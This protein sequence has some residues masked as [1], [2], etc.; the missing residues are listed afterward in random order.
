[1]SSG[2]SAST[3]AR[4]SRAS[5][6]SGAPLPFGASTWDPSLRHLLADG[7]SGTELMK[8]GLRQGECPDA[9]S[10]DRPRDV[11]DLAAA[12]Y[13]A[14]SDIVLTNSFG[15]SRILLERHGLS[16]RTREINLAA[17]RIAASARDQA[18]AA[19]SGPAA[20]SGSVAAKARPLA[21]AGDIG[22]CGK[23]FVMGEVEED[24][25]YD[26]FAEQAQALAE[27]GADWFVVE[28]MMDMGEMEIAVRAAAAT[29]KPV[30]ASMTYQPTPMGFRTLMGNSPEDC[31][32]AAT[33]A[34]AALI[35]ANCGSGVDAYV[36]LARTLRGLTALP[37]WIK[38][39]AGLPE[40]V[41]GKTVH[42]MG[43]ETYAAFIPALLEAGADV[44]G[45]CCG[46][47]PDYIRMIRPLVR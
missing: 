15:A 14:G 4:P 18:M 33:A 36:E 19:A 27:G 1:M 38:A 26:A 12:Y 7:A 39:N 37:L 28:T 45:G 25:L 2:N 41:D 10:L 31:V 47:S 42:R 30:V 17:A 9:W 34:G 22:P 29:G 43:A 3:D 13:A 24:E 5:V 44:V 20:V 11:F 46:T 32:A 16:G 8:R 21:V 6:P 23:L 40:L 35:G